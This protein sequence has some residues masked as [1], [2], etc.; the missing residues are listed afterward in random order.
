MN[1]AYEADILVFGLVREQC[2]DIWRE[3]TLLHNYLGACMTFM[4]ERE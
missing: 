1:A 4:T 2:E 3:I